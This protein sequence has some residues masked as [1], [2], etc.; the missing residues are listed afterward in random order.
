[1]KLFFFFALLIAGLG[2]TKDRLPAKFEMSYI[3]YD[4]EI[5]AGSNVFE[6]HYFRFEN[7]PT[8][9]DNYLSQNNLSEADIKEIVP[10]FCRLTAR[11]PRT[12]LN[13]L[14]EVSVRVYSPDNPDK[15]FEVFYDDAVPERTGTSL[16]LIPNDNSIKDILS[17]DRFS[18]DVVLRQLRDTPIQPI[19]TSLEVVFDAR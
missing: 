14:I 8:N 16:T 13:L 5:P 6:S 9:F 17:K 7:V 4:F 2:C 3:D 19:E 10:G 18:F 1:M 15:W 11:D 12:P